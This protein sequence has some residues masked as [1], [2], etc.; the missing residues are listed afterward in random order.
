[1]VRPATPLGPVGLI[2]PTFP[3]T[4]QPSWSAISPSSRTTGSTAGTGTPDAETACDP[5]AELAETC[6]AAEAL[7]VDALWATDHLFWHGPALECMTALTVAATATRRA[8]LGTCVVQ[9]PLRQA[10]AIA[11]QAASLQSL[12]QGR[13][14]LGVGVGSHAGEYEVSGIDYATRGHQLDEGIAQVRRAWASGSSIAGGDSAGEAVAGGDAAAGD[15]AGG[16]I[17]VGDIAGGSSDRYRQ[18]PAPPAIPL[19]VGGSSEAA[20]R[21]AASSADGWIPMLLAP[22]EYSAALARLAKEIDRADRADDAVTRSVVLFASI[23]D[24]TDEGLRRGTAWMSSLYGIPAKA[25]RRHLVVGSA[26]S[27]ARTVTD[28]RVAGAEHVVL[29]ITDDQPLPQVDRLMAAL[30]L[31]AA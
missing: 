17:A 29:Y 16:H 30:S 14:V 27:V 19:W 20:L 21:R 6:R 8:M 1:M 22:E 12:T 26:E 18:L 9:L 28:Y 23:D 11:K 5:L 25:F 4:I 24:D 31:S 13:M 10:P 7:G 3:Q 15:M 2:L